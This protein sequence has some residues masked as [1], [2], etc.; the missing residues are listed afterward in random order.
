MPTGVVFTIL[1]VDVQKAR[2]IWITRGWGARGTSWL[3]DRGTFYGDTADEQ[4]WNDLALMLTQPVCG[5]PIRLVFIDSGFRPG[6]PDELPLNRIY[7]FCRRFPRLVRPTKGSSKPLR[8]PLVVSKIEVTTAGKAA[9]YGLDLVRLDTDHWKSWVHER[10]RWPQDQPGAWNLPIDIDD[11]YCLQIVS[12]A[13]LRK[14]SGGAI[15]VRKSR[16]N[17]FL[18]CEAMQAAAAFMLNVQRITIEQADAF[19]AQRVNEAAAAPAPA[20]APRGGDSDGYWGD[21]GRGGWWNR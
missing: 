14:P 18:D 11:D 10:V 6:K 17:H 21:R 20:S 13:R 16:E 2:L 7:D 12:E 5:L 4:V 3:I 9:K 1:T 8:T 19:N 15:W